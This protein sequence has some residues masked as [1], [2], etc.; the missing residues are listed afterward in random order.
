MRDNYYR[1]YRESD[2]MADQEPTET[3]LQKYRDWL[4]SADHQASLDFDKAIMTL[5]GGALGLSITFLHDIVPKPLPQT[6]IWLWVGWIAFAA[7]LALILVSYL[8]SMAALTKAIKQVD[9]GTIYKTKTG[10]L[11]NLITIALNYLSALGVLVGVIGLVG[12]ALSN[13]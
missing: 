8:F 7:S 1:E 13:F 3:P 12:F 6:I 10:G 11:A 9:D 2:N 4:V 5:S